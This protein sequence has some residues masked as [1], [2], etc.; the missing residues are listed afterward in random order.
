MDL[1][2]ITPTGSALEGFYEKISF[3]TPQGMVEILED[4]ASFVCEISPGPAYFTQGEVSEFLF[5]SNGFA[6]VLDNKVTLIVHE[7]RQYEMDRP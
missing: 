7:T 5:I 4:H 1:K 3:H 6:K 2:I